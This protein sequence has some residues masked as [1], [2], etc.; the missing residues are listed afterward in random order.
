MRNFEPAYHEM[1]EAFER[2]DEDGNGSIEFGE[3]TALML[4]IDH[5]RSED[6][7]RRQFAAIDTNGDGR[8]SFDE[9]HAWFGAGR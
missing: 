6:A 1:K 7:L 3:F 9:F 4:E 5:A 8:V 2:F